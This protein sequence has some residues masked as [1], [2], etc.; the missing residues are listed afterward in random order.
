MNTNK[1]FSGCWLRL[2]YGLIEGIQKDDGNQLF[3]LSWFNNPSV[4]FNNRCN[5]RVFEDKRTKKRRNVIVYPTHVCF[6]LQQA[7][8][9]Q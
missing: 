7:S 3:N 8:S 9:V 4:A 2:S 5:A 1:K 6:A